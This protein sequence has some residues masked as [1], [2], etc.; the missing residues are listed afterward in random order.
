ML[1]IARLKPSQSAWAREKF[2]KYDNLD[3]FIDDGVKEGLE[4]FEKLHR[5][6]KDFY[7]QPITKE[8]LEFIRQHPGMLS[9][10]RDGNK[11]CLTSFPADMV[12]Y[13]K[14]SDTRMLRML[15]S[16]NDNIGS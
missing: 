3:D 2:L 15:S 12:E 1:N 14:A 16:N 6:G 8:V 5:E 4:E 9:G 7:D 10:V 13:L 11:I